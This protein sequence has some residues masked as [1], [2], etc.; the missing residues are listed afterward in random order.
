VTDDQ[1]DEYARR[2]RY[3][4]WARQ[5]FIAVGFH[6]ESVPITC[7]MLRDAEQRDPVA[8]D[9]S[10]AMFVWVSRWWNPY[11][12]ATESAE[13]LAVLDEIAREHRL[14]QELAAL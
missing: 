5:A 10:T 11:R 4:N 8:A 12:T 3:L 9:I 2:A 1:P 6:P 13:R 14:A 7:R